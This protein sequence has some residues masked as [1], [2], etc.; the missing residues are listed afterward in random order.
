MVDM[1]THNSL[2][3]FNCENKECQKEYDLDQ[4]SDVVLLWGY[5]YLIAEEYEAGI[6]GLTCPE[7]RKTTLKKLPGYMAMQS[8]IVLRKK[9]LDKY[10]EK[11]YI[12]KPEL[13]HCIYFSAH[14]LVA[15]NLIDALPRLKDKGIEYSIP[16]ELELNEYS[17]T[18]RAKN[19]FVVSENEIPLILEIENENGFKSF[20]RAVPSTSIYMNLDK[21]YLDNEYEYINLILNRDL[22]RPNTQED[23]DHISEYNSSPVKT[24][25]LSLDEFNGFQ[26]NHLSWKRKSFQNNLDDF[27]SAIPAV[28]N[29]ID[30]ELTYRNQLINKYARKFYYQTRTIEEQKFENKELQEIEAF[31]LE[32]II[33]VDFSEM[34]SPVPINSMHGGQLM[35]K[36]E[37]DAFS[38]IDLIKHNGL[39]AY[40]SVYSVHINKDS[41]HPALVAELTTGDLEQ[42]KVSMQRLRFDPSNVKNYEQ[43]HPEI[44]TAATLKAP[45]FNINAPSE[46][47]PKEMAI[48]LCRAAAQK[49]VDQSPEITLPAIL[50]NHEFKKSYRGKEDHIPTSDSGWRNW[51]KGIYNSQKGRKKGS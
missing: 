8:L 34:D 39:V 41:F 30:C 21:L 25:D 14:H 13:K 38:I 9:C 17:E 46:K 10:Q 44:L 40:D 37:M 19:P 33:G 12:L 50:K 36:W 45:Q 48:E 22:I 7:C 47:T 6:V 20:P 32:K 49:L 16:S 11:A 27:L 35:E 3:P 1:K 42:Q 43:H 51:L 28:R 18:L 24:N 2:F 31:G 5:I 29:S 15:S 23:V 4:F 26:C